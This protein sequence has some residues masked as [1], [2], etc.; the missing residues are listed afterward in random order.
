[1]DV[2]IFF[3]LAHSRFITKP[4][5]TPMATSTFNETSILDAVQEM[6][7]DVAAYPTREFHFPTGRSACLHVGY[8][9]SE[10]D[11]LPAG[12][13]ES[14]AGVGYPFLASIIQ[15]GDTVV[16][17]GSG[18]GV[19]VLV[20]GLKTGASGLVYGIDMTRAMIEKA[21][22]NIRR[23]GMD[24]VRVIEGRADEIPLDSASVD[25]VTS[26]GVI[27][28]VPDKEKVFRE[29]YRILKPGGRIQISDIVLSKPVSDKSKADPQLWAECI[30]GAET[31]DVYLEMVRSAGFE[32]VT[33]IDRLD[34]F[35]KSAN[36]GTRKAAQ[37]LGAHT[38]VL[39]GRKR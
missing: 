21:E 37:G 4:F 23:A 32:A 6:Y 3:T 19:D 8:P 30:V 33:V 14:F 12:A 20:A 10:I 39:T 5:R 1:M 31:E 27:N 26:N 25:V 34:Y 35:A 9:E 13:V 38:V 17:V 36:E 7:K 24:Y 29:I 28:L 16:D 11:A 22:A 18:S 2:S 15:P